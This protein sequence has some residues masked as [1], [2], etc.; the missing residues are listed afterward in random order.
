M[1]KLIAAVTTVLGLGATMATADNSALDYDQMLILDA[2]DLAEA[3]IKNA[4]EKLEP[5]MKAHDAKPVELAENIDNNLPSYSV[6]A[7][8]VTYEIYSPVLPNSEGESWGRATYAFFTIV[9]SQL[10]QSPVKFYAINGG[11]DLGGMFLTEQQVL[12]AK[13]SLKNRTDWPYLPTLKHPW[14]GQYH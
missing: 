12:A 7:S 2:E 9:N 4:Y 1:K 8:G 13:R 6:S 10:K 14:Y 11:N 5:M 3:G